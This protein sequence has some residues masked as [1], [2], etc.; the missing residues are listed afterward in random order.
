[1]FRLILIMLVGLLYACSAVGTPEQS[2]KQLTDADNGNSIELSVG[3]KIE[4]ELPGNPTTGFQWEVSDVDSIILSP[5]GEPEFKP[6]SNAVGSGGNVILRFEAVGAGQ[7]E[8]KLIHHRPFEKNVPP[9]Q[10][11]EVIVTVK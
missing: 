2:T 6:S 4:I 7:T 5:I 1:M 11:F 3:D 10:T 8:L 9:I